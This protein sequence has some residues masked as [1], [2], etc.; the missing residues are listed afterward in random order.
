MVPPVSHTHLSVSEVLYRCS[1]GIHCNV[2]D[3]KWNICSRI[4]GTIYIFMELLGEMFQCAHKQI[5]LREGKSLGKTKQ[6]TT[7][8]QNSFIEITL[9]Q[10]HKKKPNSGDGLYANALREVQYVRALLPSTNICVKGEAA[11]QTFQTHTDVGSSLDHC[12]C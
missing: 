12:C 8:Q 5:L 3:L 6:T 10:L 1:D 2:L 4:L 11:N 9:C 7:V